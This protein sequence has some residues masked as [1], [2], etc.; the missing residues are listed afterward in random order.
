MRQCRASSSPVRT[1]LTPSSPGRSCQD[2]VRS[3]LPSVPPLYLHVHWHSSITGA[4]EKTSYSN[5]RNLVCEYLDANN[6]DQN[7]TLRRWTLRL[8]TLLFII[9][10]A[11]WFC[12]PSFSVCW[13]H[14]NSDRNLTPEQRASKILAENPLIGELDPLFGPVSLLRLTNRWPQ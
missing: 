8:P 12:S 5:V 4:M 14:Q 9:S 1:C 3:D 10:C 11:A 2:L 6:A 7:A 13:S